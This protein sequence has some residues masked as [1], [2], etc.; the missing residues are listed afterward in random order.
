M[1]YL[2]AAGF[3]FLLAFVFFIFL[4]PAP[5]NITQA[6]APQPR[7]TI[8]VGKARISVE[9]ARDDLSRET[10]LMFRKSLNADSG[11]LF[12]FEKPAHQT[13]W[14]K[15]TL[16]PL[17]ILFFDETQTLVG[18]AANTPACKADPCPSVDGG[19]SSSQY[20]LEL[21]AG[22]AAREGFVTGQTHLRLIGG[23][24]KAPAV[25]QTTPPRPAGRAGDD[26]KTMPTPAQG[27]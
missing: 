21:P 4:V 13:F 11:M 22:R 6:Q 24:E 23:P 5:L 12:V 16:I 14:M 3:F 25:Q 18:I 17:D 9:L 19:A 27:N 15:N 2:I 26:D 10:G 1:K 8:E 7:Q 20:V